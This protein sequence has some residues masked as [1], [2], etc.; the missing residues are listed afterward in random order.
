MLKNGDYVI[1][2]QKNYKEEEY[3]IAKYFWNDILVICKDKDIG[4][5]SFSIKSNAFTPHQHKTL[6]DALDNV[7]ACLKEH[8]TKKKVRDYNSK[9]IIVLEGNIQ[10]E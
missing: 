3:F 4:I 8:K 9:E 6:E 1:V 5:F 10:D 2:S 7:K